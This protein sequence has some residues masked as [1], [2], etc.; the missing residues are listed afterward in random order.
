MPPTGLPRTA[1]RG[2]EIQQ[3]LDTDPPNTPPYYVS[4]FDPDNNNAFYSAYK[5]TLQQAAGL[6]TFSRG[7]INVKSWRTPGVPGLKD[8]YST[9]I[10]ETAGSPLSRGHMNPVALNTFS[11][12]FM[13]ATF[14]FS[15]AVPQFEKS[16]C[17]PWEL[18]E[19]RLQKY[20]KTGC[21]AQGGTLYLLTGKSDYGVRIQANSPVQ[22]TTIP[23]PYL[24]H[25]FPGNIALGTP[26]AV[27]TAG[28]CVWADPGKNVGSSLP[29]KTAESFAV[30]SNNQDD[31]ASLHQ[32]EMSVSQLES[33]LKPPA[34]LVDVKLF[35]GNENCGKAENSITLP[36]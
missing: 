5:V 22:D 18:F 28:C 17:G 36:N 20:A 33:I 3:T 31:A 1:D 14:T 8:A 13:K 4:L 2:R 7:D 25:N 27:W 24:R 34:S 21:G 19:T 12:D 23:L 10:A 6:G 29:A 16:N 9:A 11:K 30:I 32:T 15:N 35:P 26:R